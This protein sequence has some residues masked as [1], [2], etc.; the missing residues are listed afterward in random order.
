MPSIINDR[1]RAQRLAMLKQVYALVDQGMTVGKAA[2][3][4]GVSRGTVYKAEGEALRAMSG[5]DTESSA[6]LMARITRDP[7]M[8]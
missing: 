6:E 5:N 2:K 8:D 1:K 7:L 3:Q 4:L